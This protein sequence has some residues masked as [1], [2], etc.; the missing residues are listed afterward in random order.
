MIV[1]S[2]KLQKVLQT[3]YKTKIEDK[4]SIQKKASVKTDSKQDKVELSKE[5]KEF[6]LA[7]EIISKSDD[8]RKGKVDEIKKRI[9]QG[10]YNIEGEKV[11]EKIL[12]GISVDELI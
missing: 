8:I 7:M 12:D 2:N 5:A 3:Y 6:M 11:A 4:T 10:T 9:E 1:P